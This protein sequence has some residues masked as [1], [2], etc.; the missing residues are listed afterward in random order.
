MKD[1]NIELLEDILK[2]AE[3]LVFDFDD[4]LVDESYSI[5]KR[6]DDVLTKYEKELKI[7]DIKKHFF[8]I[9]YKEGKD[10]K[11]HLDDTIKSLMI[12]YKYKEKILHDFLHQK[13]KHELLYPKVKNTLSYLKNLNKF[14]MAIYTNGTIGTHENRIR[15]S[16]VTS[17]FEYI[18]YG[19]SFK[20]KPDK[21]SFRMLATKLNLTNKKSFVMIGD[22]YKN[23]YLGS[24]LYGAQCVLI[25][26]A[27][28]NTLSCPAFKTFEDFY[29][30][31][32]IIENRIY[33]KCQKES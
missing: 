17:F 22:D 24:K 16:G 1:K 27:T 19:D 11:F 4:T 2:N 20:P 5:E 31:L 3:A 12:D 25:N 7:T 15:L 33:D 13:A 32:K 18:Q 8:N 28:N 9:Y 30:A 23:D 10:Y 29:N 26:T 6:W 21:N 14:K